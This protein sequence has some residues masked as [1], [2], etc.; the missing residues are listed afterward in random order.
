MDE[1]RQVLRQAIDDAARARIDWR[2][3]ERCAGCGVE[4]SDPWTEEARYA[5]GCRV[6]S[7][8]RSKRRSR[9]EE[10]QLA[11]EGMAA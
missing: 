8:R 5:V 7:D 3:E 10:A 6:C 11:L 1:F 9:A 2:A 4:Q